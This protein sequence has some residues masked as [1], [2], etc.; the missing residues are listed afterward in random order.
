LPWEQSSGAILHQSDGVAGDLEGLAQRLSNKRELVDLLTLT[1]Q[2]SSRSVRAGATVEEY[3]HSGIGGFLGRHCL[4]DGQPE[5][6]LIDA[7]PL[8]FLGSHTRR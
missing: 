1:R 2:W 8:M 6:S 5:G 4:A 7:V 3:S